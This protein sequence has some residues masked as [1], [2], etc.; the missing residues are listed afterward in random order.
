MSSPS[1]ELKIEP[2]KNPALS[3]ACCLI[4]VGFLTYSSTLKV[5]VICSFET[6]VHFHPTTRRCVPEGRTL[7]SNHYLA[8]HTFSSGD[9][10][11]LT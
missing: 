9:R 3:S 1:S 7:Q 5:E 8:K 10:S 4:I 2:S 11:V 6:L